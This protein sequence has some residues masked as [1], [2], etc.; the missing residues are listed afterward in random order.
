M[1]EIRRTLA[2]PRPLAPFAPLAALAVLATLV[3]LVAILAVCPAQALAAND[4]AGAGTAQGANVTPTDITPVEEDPTNEVNVHLLPDGSFIYETSIEDLASADAFYNDQTVVV[5]GEVVGDRVH[6]SDGGNW[7]VLSSIQ[8]T[9][10]TNGVFAPATVTVYVTDSMA[11]LIDTY[12]EYDVRGSIVQVSGVFNLACREHEGVSD[13]HASE[14]TVTQTGQVEKEPI[15]FF[16]FL[17]G[18]AA[19]ALGG[20]IALVYRFLRE[21]RR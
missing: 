8:A 13:I 14:L 1:A 5:M 10:K 12:G 4:T 9:A 21:K 6:A 3:V 17:P 11:D 16:D 7:I 2:F 18:L 15:N 19:A 20:L